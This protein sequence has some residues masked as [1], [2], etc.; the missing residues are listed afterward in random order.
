MSLNRKQAAG[1]FSVVD[2]LTKSLKAP[3]FN[4]ILL[5]ADLNAAVVQRP[6]FGFIGWQINYLL[7]GLPLMQALSPD[8]F[9]AVVA[10]ELA[11]LSGDDSRFSG[12]IYRVRQ[13]WFELAE[14]FQSDRQGGFFFRQFFSWYGPFFKAYSFVL[15][16]AQEYE[17]RSTSRPN[18]RR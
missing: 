14:K 4:H 5:T 9:R 6:R 12:W 10:H 18:C 1:L 16:R 13:A 3:Q 11:H 17:G 2:E 7:L 15:A 8:Q